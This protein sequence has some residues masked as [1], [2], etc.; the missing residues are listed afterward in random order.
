MTEGQTEEYKKPFWLPRYLPLDFIEK[1]PTDQ[2]REE[3]CE[4][5]SNH[6]REAV[7]QRVRGDED[8]AKMISRLLWRYT[9][10]SIHF[11]NAKERRGEPDNWPKAVRK[12][13]T[14]EQREQRLIGMRMMLDTSELSRE[15]QIID[16]LIEKASAIPTRTA[17]DRIIEGKLVPK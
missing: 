3:L 8:K 13:V 2:G 11:L 1:A 9:A 10:S 15:R 7:E 4:W 16:H 14:L 17:A 5:I 12:K 6:I